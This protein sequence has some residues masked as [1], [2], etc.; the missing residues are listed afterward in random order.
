MAR[1]LAEGTAGELAEVWLRSGVELR[2]AAAFPLDA[3]RLSVSSLTRQPVPQRRR[4]S[5]T[6]A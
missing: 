6:P 1:V 3:V 5:P 2:R 4:P